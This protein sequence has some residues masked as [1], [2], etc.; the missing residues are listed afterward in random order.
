MDLSPG[1]RAVPIKGDPADTVKEEFIS[2]R[3][4]SIDGDT[5][6]VETGALE[7]HHSGCGC[8]LHLG[9]PTDKPRFL[10]YLLTAPL[11]FG[12]SARNR[13]NNRGMS[14]SSP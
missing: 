1:T 14:V 8:V 12:N 13:L 11:E 4:Y 6:S 5:V 9:L 2:A 10:I 7:H 3:S